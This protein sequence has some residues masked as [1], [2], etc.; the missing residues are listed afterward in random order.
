MTHHQT[1]LLPRRNPIDL[2]TIREQLLLN[3]RKFGNLLSLLSPSPLMLQRFL[4]QN[5]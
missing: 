4:R 1:S 5:R 2:D 3:M